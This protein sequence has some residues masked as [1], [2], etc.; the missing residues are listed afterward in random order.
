MKTRACS[1]RTLKNP[2]LAMPAKLLC[3]QLC[4]ISTSI[5]PCKICVK[6]RHQGPKTLQTPFSKFPSADT[7]ETVAA[8]LSLISV[9][10]TN[11]ALL[12]QQ[13]FLVVSLNSYC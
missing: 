4:A 11:L 5:L 7:P 1:P 9:L 2:S 12:D 13:V 8:V 10:L 6:T 3:H